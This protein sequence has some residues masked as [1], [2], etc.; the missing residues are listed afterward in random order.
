MR[1]NCCRRFFAEGSAVQGSRGLSDQTRRAKRYCDNY[2]WYRYRDRWTSRVNRMCFDWSIESNCFLESN[3]N[4]KGEIGLE[5]I[6]HRRIVEE[7]QPSLCEN[8]TKVT[9]NVNGECA[10]TRYVFLETFCKSARDQTDKRRGQRLGYRKIQEVSISSE[11]ITLSRDLYN[12]ART[13]HA[14]ENREDGFIESTSRF[15]DASRQR[16]VIR[17]A[18]KARI[19]FIIIIF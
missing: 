19:I 9:R 17:H 11:L 18:R 2:Q 5:W 10:C 1:I 7:A 8:S 6:P 14:F 16:E 4:F 12:V 15:L 13:G 3:W